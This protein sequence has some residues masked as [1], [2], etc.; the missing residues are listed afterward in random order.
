MTTFTRTLR[1]SRVAYLY[2][3]YRCAY[4]FFEFR[5]YLAGRATALA[6]A[7]YAAEYPRTRQYLIGAWLDYC[8]AERTLSK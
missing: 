3:K 6:H 2:Y 5:R 7:L 4:R 1:V 8:E